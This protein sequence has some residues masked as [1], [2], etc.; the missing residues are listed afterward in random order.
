VIYDQREERSGWGYKLLTGAMPTGRISAYSSADGI[1]WLP[2]A[3]T[4]LLA[5]VRTA[6]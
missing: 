3:E 2:G 1:D 4:R 6:L 5:L